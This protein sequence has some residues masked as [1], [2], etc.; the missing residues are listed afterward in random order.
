MLQQKITWNL[1]ANTLL[2]CPHHRSLLIHLYS[3]EICTTYEMFIHHTIRILVRL[4]LQLDL[5][6]RTISQIVGIYGKLLCAID[7]S[8][9]GAHTSQSIVKAQSVLAST[10]MR[11]SSHHGVNGRIFW[12]GCQVQSCLSL[13]KSFS[14]AEV[15]CLHTGSRHGH[16]ILHHTVDEG[17]VNVWQDLVFLYL[18]HVV[19]LVQ[20]IIKKLLVKGIRPRS[21]FPIVNLLVLSI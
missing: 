11:R 1:L 9:V 18:V 12:L 16:L 5:I 2:K 13:L 8:H 21:P 4:R 20:N 10:T 19:I 15:W 6:L 14:V 7:S 17:V 3:T